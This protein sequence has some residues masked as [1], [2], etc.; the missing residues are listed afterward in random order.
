MRSEYDK[1]IHGIINGEFVSR[2]EI[3]M[4]KEFLNYWKLQS[5]RIVNK[6]VVLIST[7]DNYTNLKPQD[8]GTITGIDDAGT[9]FVDWDCGSTLGL[10]PGIDQFKVLDLDYEKV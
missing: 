9:I 10:I 4:F 6:R 7:S 5:N 2:D 3:N 1:V 8:I